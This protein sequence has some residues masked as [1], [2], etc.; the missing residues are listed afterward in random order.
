M[1]VTA[2]SMC[3]DL[4]QNFFIIKLPFV[5]CTLYIYLSNYVHYVQFILSSNC[6]VVERHF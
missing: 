4:H 6:F 5:F 2:H 1:C 3:V